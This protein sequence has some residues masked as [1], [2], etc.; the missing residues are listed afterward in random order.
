[1]SKNGKAS[2]PDGVPAEALK[3]DM[4]S[5]ANILH[6]LFKKIWDKPDVPDEWKEGLSIKLPKSC[7]LI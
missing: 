1:M 5:T 4:I 3:V 6:S 2:G 7:N